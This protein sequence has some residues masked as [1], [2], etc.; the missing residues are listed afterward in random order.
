MATCEE[1]AAIHPFR[2]DKFELAPQMG[3]DKGEHQTAINT[4]IIEN[5]IRKGT[6]V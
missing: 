5:S 4:V 1:I 3:A 2:L 6:T